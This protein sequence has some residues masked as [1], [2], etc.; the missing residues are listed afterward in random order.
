MNFI[1]FIVIFSSIWWVVFFM[2]LPFGVK[3]P[4]KISTGHADS[5]PDNP[6]IALKAFITTLISILITWLIVFL[7]KNN[8]FSVLL[9]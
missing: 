6:K 8:Y 2:I 9:G 3:I 1:T 7:F 5:A 4:L